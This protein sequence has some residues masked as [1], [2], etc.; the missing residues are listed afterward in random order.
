M[1]RDRLADRFYAIVVGRW[2]NS[3]L[4]RCADAALR[5]CRRDVLIEKDQESRDLRDRVRVR[6][7]GFVRA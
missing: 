1:E 4:G 2:R 3:A 5:A 7:G 6:I